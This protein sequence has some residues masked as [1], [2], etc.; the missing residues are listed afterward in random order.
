MIHN[1]KYRILTLLLICIILINFIMIPKQ[2]EAIALTLGALGLTYKVAEALYLFVLASASIGVTYATWHE[3][4]KVYDMYE[5]TSPAPLY[6]PDWQEKTNDV[7][8][9]KADLAME[10]WF[11]QWGLEVLPGGLPPN[12]P[13][14]EGNK[15]GILGLMGAIGVMGG[16]ISNYLA[17]FKTL[18]LEDGENVIS[19]LNDMEGYYNGYSYKLEILDNRSVGYVYIVINNTYPKVQIAD[20]WYDSSVIGII[21]GF[22]IKNIKSNGNNIDITMAY[23]LKSITK[24]GQQYMDPRVY[25]N[26]NK[27]IPKNGLEEEEMPPLSP[28]NSIKI[29]IKPNS[30]VV[31]PHKEP[32]YPQPNLVPIRRLRPSVAPDGSSVLDYPGSA[33]E[34]LND[35]VMNTPIKEVLNPEGNPYTIIPNPDGTVRIVPDY[36]PTTPYPQY[37]KPVRPEIWPPLTPDP[38]I[39]PEE[40]PYPIWPE[41]DPNKWPPSIPYPTKPDPWPPTE[42]IPWPD[43]DTWPPTIPYPYPDPYVWPEQVPYPWPDPTPQSP[44]SPQ[45]PVEPGKQID[46]TPWLQIII[47]WLAKI[48]IKIPDKPQPE[49]E[50]I[51]LQGHIDDIKNIIS[52]KINIP[53]I[54]GLPGMF[55]II[56]C[57]PIPNQYIDGNIVVDTTNVNEIASTI[58]SWQ[59]YFWIVMIILAGANN[60]YK[61]IRGTSLI[62]FN[63]GDKN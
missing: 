60:A 9:S 25:N 62:G 56:E 27:K 38:S 15:R 1:K 42:P 26:L 35:I 3:A 5:G 8:E 12:D 10:K 16:F 23:T 39:W 4:K 28:E 43:P 54:G 17:M 41:P 18:E 50:P 21:E 29:N 34:L 52:E 14:P 49:P 58:R 13:D 20:Y 53:D 40:V 11:S 6:F 59:R 33:D 19:L 37:P 22:K 44:P 47:N 31:S 45:T 32:I 57:E 2:V 46:Y 24:N 48:W 61:L 63:R 55:G 51:G 36:D 7:K 30:P